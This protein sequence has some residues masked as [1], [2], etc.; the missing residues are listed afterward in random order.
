MTAATDKMRDR[1]SKSTPK[2]LD[3]IEF[4]KTSMYWDMDR[5]MDLSQDYRA[6]KWMQENV[7]GSPV[8]IEANT[9]EYKWGN[10]YTIYTGLTG[11]LGLELASKAAARCN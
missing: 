11:S 4:M 3:G 9:V 1:M 7:Q 6:I 10:R 8:L 2:T 5:Q